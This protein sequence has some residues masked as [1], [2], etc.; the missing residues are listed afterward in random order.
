MQG[1]EVPV[2]NSFIFKGPVFNYCG[3]TSPL[4][5]VCKEETGWNSPYTLIGLRP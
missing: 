1:E 2:A 4:R 3:D 5:A